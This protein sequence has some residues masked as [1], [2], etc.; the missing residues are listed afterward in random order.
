MANEPQMPLGT[1]LAVAATMQRNV[2]Q[3]DKFVAMRGKDVRY[4]SADDIV[5]YIAILVNTAEQLGALVTQELPEPR[6]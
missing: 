3:I 5:A 1:V 4:W 2:D 6:P